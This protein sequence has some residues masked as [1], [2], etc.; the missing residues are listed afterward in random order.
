MDP[1]D[2]GH[3]CEC[4]ACGQVGSVSDLVVLL[5]NEVAEAIN[6]LGLG[7]KYVGIYAYNQH[8]PPPDIR[9]H[10]NVVVSVATSFIRGGYTI[11]QLVEGW[12][13]KGAVLGVREYHDVFPWSHDMPRR[14]RGGNLDI[15]PARSPI[16]SSTAPGT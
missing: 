7:P 2:G 16:S 13:A 6:G 1:S 15:W 14:A 11:E 12:A 4:D 9:V 8:S 3:W 10:P 5:A